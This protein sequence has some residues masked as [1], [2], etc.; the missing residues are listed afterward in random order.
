MKEKH[1]RIMWSVIVAV[2]VIAGFF[3]SLRGGQNTTGAVNLPQDFVI[4]RQNAA[5][6]SQHIVDLT[7]AT[8][9]KINAANVSELAGDNKKTQQFIDEARIINN[10]A[11]QNAS[12]LAEFLKNLAGSL[13]TLQSTASQRIAY[14]AIATE[15]SLVS[16]FIVYTQNL[17]SFLD[18]LSAA[19]E[20]NTPV[21]KTA[22]EATLKKTN[23]SAHTIND[24]NKEFLDRMASFDKSL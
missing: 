17:N 18:A 2:L 10:E 1:A 7:S 4:A 20:G 23:S 19:G 9:D 13:T 12:N 5:G 6:V 21:R 24:L 14:Q 15:L 8:R 3:Y 11:Y 16:E 22:I